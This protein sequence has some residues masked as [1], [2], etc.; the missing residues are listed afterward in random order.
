[1]WYVK[2]SLKPRNRFPIVTLILELGDSLCFIEH[3]TSGNIK[4]KHKN[5]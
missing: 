5:Y 1:M 4:V 3:L 2:K